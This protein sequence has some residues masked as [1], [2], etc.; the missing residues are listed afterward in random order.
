MIKLAAVI[1]TFNE[2]VNIER[3][4]KS[5]QSVVDEIV[6]VDSHSTDQTESICKRYNAKFVSHDWEGYTD[7]KNYANSLV[8]SDYILSIDADE[9]LSDQLKES[10]LNLKQVPE[11]NSVWVVSRL[12]NYCGTWI[13]HGGWY[14]DKKIRLWKKDDGLWEGTLHEQV[15]FKDKVTEI[16]LKGDLLHYSYYTIQQHIDRANKYSEIGAIAAVERGRKMNQ[17]KVICYPFW[18]FIRTYFL[19]LGFLDGYMGFVV[20]IISTHE[21]FLK[22]AKI[23]QMQNNKSLKS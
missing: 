12:T 9:A 14:P 13:K 4:L 5:M 16:Q 22:Y 23:R 7:T 17:L 15:V 3:C 6:V 2:E 10:L 19:K 1:I 21:A 18:K 8:E 11:K 20:C